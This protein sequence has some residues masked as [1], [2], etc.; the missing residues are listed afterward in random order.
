MAN[1]LIKANMS[2]V[3]HMFLVATIVSSIV[4]CSSVDTLRAKEL[5]FPKDDHYDAVIRTGESVTVLVKGG[6]LDDLKYYANEDGQ[7]FVQFVFP[8]DPHCDP[9]F[10]YAYESLPDGRLQVWKSCLTGKGTLT[11]LMAYDWHTHKLEQLSGSL[12]LGSSGASWN[13]DQTNAI[14]Y[15]D[16]GFATKTLYWISKDGFSPLDLVI[17]DQYRSWNL[18][19]DFP[20]FKADDT[21]QTGTTGRAAWSPS[22]KL[23]AFF[24]SP[25]AIGKT[26]FAR[27]GVEFR[28]Y[29][30]DPETMQYQVVAD[31]IY[32]PFLLQWS[33]DSTQIVFIGKYG[34]QK[35]NGIWL[36]SVNTKSITNISKGDFK[37]LVWR[38]DGRN[39]VAIRCKDV[40][41]CAQV[42]NYDL[43]NIVKP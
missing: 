5:T 36:Y 17:G 10:Y 43:T 39:L 34:F 4:S 30:M 25:D 27:F 20:D 2:I 13:P 42:L 37:S 8:D 24:A 19:D 16:G 6:K 15:L 32:S 9:V 3:T 41:T 18:R 38:P 12:P 14:A 22:G 35:E 29:L 21:G 11:Y 40:D 7:E 28:L 1:K 31:Q 26:G 33:P 23:I